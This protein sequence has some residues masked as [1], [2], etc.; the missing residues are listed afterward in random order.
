[1]KKKILASNWIPDEC[2][3]GYDF[4]IDCPTF[5]KFMYQD[6]EL[7]ELIKGYDGLMVMK[8]TCRK[9]VLDAGDKLQVVASTSVGFDNIDHEY[10]KEQGI[11]VCHCPKN[12]IEPTA[13][14]AFTLTCTLSRNIREWD[15]IVRRDKECAAKF[16][17]TV[18]VELYGKTVGVV[19]FGRIGR[20]YARRAKAFGMKILYWDMIQYPEEVEKEF[21]A[22]WVDLNTLLKTSDVVSLHVP[23]FENTRYLIAE[24]ELALMKKDAILINCARGPVVKESALVNALNNDQIRGAA[25]DVFENEPKVSDAVLSCKNLILTPHVGPGTRGVQIA[26][27]REALD[28]VQAVFNGEVP[29]NAVH[30]DVLPRKF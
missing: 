25:I 19:G 8:N 27:V 5:E 24:R 6:E 22:Q 10:A 11:F 30:K 12:I 1:M 18:S 21:D 28:G 17:D 3:E 4:T 9:V 23:L 2:K 15:T 7:P 16:F 29:S 26:V 20:A 13:E 14:F